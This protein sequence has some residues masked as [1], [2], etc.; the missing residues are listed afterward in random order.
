MKTEKLWCAYLDITLAVQ[1]CIAGSKEAKALSSCPDYVVGYYSK[2]KDGRALEDA[3]IT[4][5]ELRQLQ[6]AA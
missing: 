2:H 1:W 5:N 6:E 3:A 4:R